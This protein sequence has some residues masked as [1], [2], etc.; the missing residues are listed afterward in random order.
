MKWYRGG[1]GRMRRY[2]GG[3]RGNMKKNEMVVG[4]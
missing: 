1:K 2:K 4:W 3:M